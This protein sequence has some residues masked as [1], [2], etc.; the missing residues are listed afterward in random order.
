MMKG[1]VVVGLVGFSIFTSP[2]I[3]FSKKGICGFSQKLHEAEIHH[4]AFLS[5]GECY[6]IKD[7]E[8]EVKSQLQ[9]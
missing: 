8:R 2:S 9:K 1:F 4:K 5:Y 6:D 7:L 3:S